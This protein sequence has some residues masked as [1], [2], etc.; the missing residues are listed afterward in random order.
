MCFASKHPQ[1]LGTKHVSN[2]NYKGLAPFDVCLV[3]QAYGRAASRRPG[4]PLMRFKHIGLDLHISRKSLTRVSYTST[5][6]AMFT[7][8]RPPQP[9]RRGYAPTPALL[10]LLSFGRFLN[11]RSTIFLFNFDAQQTHTFLRGSYF[12]VR[13]QA[14]DVSGC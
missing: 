5:R 4:A 2:P 1:V 9:P 3:P 6:L 7:N 13:K 14:R 8:P 12:C 11:R 10:V